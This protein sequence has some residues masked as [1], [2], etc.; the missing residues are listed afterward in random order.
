MVHL[1]EFEPKGWAAYSGDVWR[2]LTKFIFVVLVS[3]P[4]CYGDSAPG[5]LRVSWEVGT[6]GCSQAG[7]ETIHAKLYNY[8]SANPSYELETACMQRRLEIASVSPSEYTL[9][10]EGLDSMGCT[11]HLTRR[12]VTVLEGQIRSLDGLSLVPLHRP[13]L[14][15]WTY[16]GTRQCPCSGAEQV[17]FEM[18]LPN[19]E[20]RLIPTLC[21]QCKTIIRDDF[22]LVE[23][24]SFTVKA[25]N[26]DG[27]AYASGTFRPTRDDLLQ[28][29]CNEHVELSV[30]LSTC[31]YLGCGEL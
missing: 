22:P 16:D 29:P 12:H 14:L 2:L 1:K 4:G 8:S 19:G 3:L 20:I 23:G 26:E 31:E 30:E 5:L 13:L 18:A 25:Y 17:A 7:V 6:L 11:T 27:D 21:D 9:V 24:L 28:E 15:T 10:L